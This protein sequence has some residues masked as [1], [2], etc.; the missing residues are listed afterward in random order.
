M[1]QIGGLDAWRFVLSCQ[2][3]GSTYDEEMLGIMEGGDLLWLLWGYG[4]PVGF[5]RCGG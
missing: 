4:E 5:R 2:S 3:E 1:E